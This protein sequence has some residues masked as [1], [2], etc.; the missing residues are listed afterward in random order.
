MSELTVDK[1]DWFWNNINIT[2]AT[3]LDED[4]LTEDEIYTRTNNIITS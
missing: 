1:Y 4:S 2:G 3:I